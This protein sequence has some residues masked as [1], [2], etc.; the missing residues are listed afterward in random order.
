MKLVIDIDDNIY[1][2][3]FDNGVDDPDDPIDDPIDIAPVIHDKIAIETAIRKGKPLPEHYGDL[4]D[5]DEL[6]FWAHEIDSMYCIYDEVVD[7]DDIKNA[8]AIIEGSDS[9]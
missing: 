7:V 2:R 1:T 8:P 5:R 9:K 4:I 6:L 3:L